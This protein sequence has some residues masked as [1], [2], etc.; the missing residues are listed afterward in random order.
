LRA[1][2]QISGFLIDVGS[3]SAALDEMSEMAKKTIKTMK[4]K[5]G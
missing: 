3:M 4:A 5:L 2:G 1:Y